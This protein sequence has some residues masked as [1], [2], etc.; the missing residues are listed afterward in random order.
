MKKTLK[1]THRITNLEA[2]KK[3]KIKELIEAIKKIVAQNIKLILV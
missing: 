1:S 3:L 2:F